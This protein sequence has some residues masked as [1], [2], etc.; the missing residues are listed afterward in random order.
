MN[1]YFRR[2][3][4]GM[5]EKLRA[6][7]VAGSMAVLVGATSYYFLRLFLAR[8]PLEPLEGASEADRQM[9]VEGSEE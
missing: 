4:A 6:G 1:R 7:L 8:E 2:R 3:E 9:I 5:E